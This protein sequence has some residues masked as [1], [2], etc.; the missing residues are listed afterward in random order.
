MKPSACFAAAALLLPACAGDIHTTRQSPQQPTRFVGSTSA[1]DEV[2][3]PQTPEDGRFV[4]NRIYQIT[5]LETADEQR[6]EWRALGET[7][8]QEGSRI[9]FNELGSG[10]T[11][12]FTGPHQITPTSSKSDRVATQA[13]SEDPA[14]QRSQAPAP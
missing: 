9:Q 11:I 14:Q 3:R 12:S 10:K 5:R 7:I 2:N 6:G 8:R 1:G 13:N 4:R